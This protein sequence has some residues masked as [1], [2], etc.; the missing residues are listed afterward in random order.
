MWVIQFAECTTKTAE[1]LDTTTTQDGEKIICPNNV[2][3]VLPQQ[4]TSKC[5]A[6]LLSLNQEE[7]TVSP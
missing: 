7:F 6:D 5:S 1:G 3:K 2:N 4:D